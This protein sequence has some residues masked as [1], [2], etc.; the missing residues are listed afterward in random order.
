MSAFQNNV[1]GQRLG[2]QSFVNGLNGAVRQNPVAAGLIGAGVAWMLLGGRGVRALASPVPA[3]ANSAASGVGSLAAGGMQGL[4]RGASA[5]VAATQS[6]AE[7]V[8]S[9]AEQLADKLT[10]ESNDGYYESAAAPAQSSRLGALY[11]DFDFNVAREKVANAFEQQP[12]LMGLAG[13]AIG[14]AVASA[15]KPTETEQEL[16]GDYAGALREQASDAVADA[17]SRAARAVEAMQDEAVV[18]GLTPSAA[19]AQVKAAAQKAMEVAKGSLG[20]SP[21]GDPSPQ[22]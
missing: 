20:G 16:L 12:L 18:Q 8:R 5:A 6:A 11:S 13:V 3:L 9:Q 17:K 21:L 10:P 19:Q 22:R 15:F 7:G 4:R 14:A 1:S 2:R